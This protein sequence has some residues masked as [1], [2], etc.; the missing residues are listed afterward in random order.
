MKRMSM[1]INLIFVMQ[2]LSSCHQNPEPETYLI[3]QGFTGRVNVIFNRKDGAPPKYE[4]GR[5]IYEIPSNGIL[6][7]QFKDEYGFVD[8]RYYY[9]DSNGKRTILKIYQHDYNKDGTVKWKVKD[10]NEI[11]IFSDGTTGQYGNTGEPKSVKWQEFFVS[12]YK[13]L[14]TMEPLDSF[15]NRVKKVIDYNF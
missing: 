8:H 6:L 4:D 5:R 14:D 3:P 13:G 1:L 11:G 12:S 9:V 7:T 15:T 2:L 10:P